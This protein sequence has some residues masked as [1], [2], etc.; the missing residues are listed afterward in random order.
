MV[1]DTGERENIRVSPGGADEG[2]HKRYCLRR[3]GRAKVK[4]WFVE[5]AKEER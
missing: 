4:Y 3:D 2:H 5:Q 1:S